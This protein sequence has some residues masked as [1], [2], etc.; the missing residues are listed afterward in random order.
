MEASTKARNTSIKKLGQD[1]F[2]SG[3]LGSK[4]MKIIN[5]LLWSGKKK[6]QIA[7][8]LLGAF[9]GLL[10]LLGSLQIYFDLQ[11]LLG[12][13]VEGNEQ[14]A[15]I[16]KHVNLFN[17]LGV[18]S[19]FTDE[20]I[21][22]IQ[23]QHFVRSVGRFTPNQF[24]VSASSSLLGFYTELFFESIPTEL[25]D[26]DTNNFQWEK[27]QKELPIILSKDYLALYNFGFAPSQGLPQFTESTIGRVSV[28][29]NI[30]GRTGGETFQGRII[31]FSDRINSILVPQSFM[32]WANDN[33]G[34]DTKQT[35]SRLIVHTTSASTD[36]LSK[37]LKTKGFELSS[38]RML[39][40]Q[41]GTILKLITG[42]I[43]LI[44][45]IILLLSIAV[46][47]LNFQLII[48]QASQDIQMLLHLG[49]H[50][51]QVS[52]MLIRN[53]GILFGLIFLGSLFVLFIGR[54]IFV[55]WASSQGI[56]LTYGLH[57]VVILV[58]ILFALGFF[59]INSMNIQKSI[60]R[61]Y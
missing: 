47:A 20:E 38:G 58:A 11:H 21:A 37:Y 4:A 54:Y 13:E 34:T 39:G 19:T 57:W 49:Y 5:K 53:M 35:A 60:E 1:L 46:F 3:P 28:D 30:K 24:R 33:Y 22:D 50:P 61:M 56:I 23:A 36:D 18:R 26:I 10:L 17:T 27:G 41:L 51:K 6:W 59:A 12:S 2:N 40:G 9:I 55:A 32:I 44:G 15:I 14:Y 52:L 31:G 42:T 29:I 25:I 43:V 8:S 16:N 45:F 7:G 48:S